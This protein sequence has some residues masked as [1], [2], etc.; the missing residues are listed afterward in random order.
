M[1]INARIEINGITKVVID[2][3]YVWN[4]YVTS[5]DEW[6]FMPDTPGKS[7][8]RTRSTA[9]LLTYVHDLIHGHGYRA[10]VHHDTLNLTH[11]EFT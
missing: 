4:R 2:R 10:R 7:L 5:K 6:W 9:S 11:P 3:K 1:Y 8:N